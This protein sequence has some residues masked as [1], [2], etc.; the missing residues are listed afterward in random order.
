MRQHILLPTDF[1]ENAYQAALYA[2]N[3]YQNTPCT[4]HFVHAWTFVN[5]GART[6]IAPNYIDVLKEAS[7]NHLKG[8]MERAK[9]TSTNKE[10]RFETIFTVD[11]LTDSIKNAVEKYHI[12]FVVMG[13]KGATGAKEF[14]LGSNTVTVIDKVRLCPLLLVPDQYNFAIPD[15]IVFAT[16]FKRKFGLEIENIKKI[17]DLHHSTI[18][19][20]HISDKEALS[21]VQ[22]QNIETLKVHLKNH[23]TTFQ[24]LP[25]KGKKEPAI[26][27]FIKENDIKFLTM[28]HYEQSLI[29]TLMKERI[30]KN[31]GFHSNTP[32]LVIPKVE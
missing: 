12:D 2:I 31:I 8:F 20:I 21:K 13:T 29:E 25:D 24:W 15:H 4:F 9:A 7:N 32:F 19:V 14:F 26:R 1:S 16:D 10:H 28:I 30:V 22:H 18:D 6:Y 3:L 17:A 11:S 27:N 5:T 23:P